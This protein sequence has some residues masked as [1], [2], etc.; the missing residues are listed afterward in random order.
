MRFFS[1]AA[2]LGAALS[3]FSEAGPVVSPAVSHNTGRMGNSL[4]A[5]HSN[6]PCVFDLAKAYLDEILYQGVCAP[7]LPGI[8]PAVYLGLTLPH[9]QVSGAVSI[10]LNDMFLIAPTVRVNLGGV[11]VAV[12]LDLKASAAVQQSVE[13]FA[14]PALQVDIPGLVDIE[15]GAA[16]ALD[17]LVGVSAAVDI[18]AG[19]YV[20]LPDAAFIEINLLTKAISKSNLEGLL[21]QALPVALGAGVDLAAEIDLNLGLRLRTQVGVEAG[22]DCVGLEAGA[23][24]ALWVDLFDYT[25]TLAHTDSCALSVA[26][27]L[28]VVAGVAVDVGVEVKDI[29][30]ISLAPSVLVTLA[31]AELAK[32]CHAT[33]PHYTATSTALALPGATGV[34]R[35]GDGAVPTGSVPAGVFPPSG[36]LRSGVIPSGGAVFPTGAPSGLPTGG[37]STDTGV[38]VDPTAVVLG[39]PTITGAPG[40]GSGSGAD[41]LTTS[42]IYSTIVETITSCAHTVTNCPAGPHVTTRTVAVGTTVCPLSN[43]APTGGPGSIGTISAIPYGNSSVTS[44]PG[45]ITSTVTST[46]VYTITSCAASVPN[47]PA[48]L[49]QKIITSTVLIGTTV[50]PATMVTATATSANTTPAVVVPTPTGTPVTVTPCPTPVTSTYTA[51]SNIPTPAP[52]VII[53][54][55]ATANPETSGAATVPPSATYVTVPTNPARIVS[56][57]APLGTGTGVV[58]PVIATSVPPTYVVPSPTIVPTAVPT[59]GA[60]RVVAGLAAMGLPVLAMML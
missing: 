53:T 21:A 29:L 20:T 51:P 36:A 30:D 42:T 15:L 4:N 9:A 2:L 6:Q 19:V 38:S 56:G 26:D 8:Q 35:V 48:S 27:A 54:E 12:E 43:A 57:T 46:A 52:T 7:A 60:G 49:T 50:C 47:C 32:I 55:T 23:Q 10:E 40:S 18:Q 45:L 58:P 33:V 22:L 37:A 24:V 41:P 44:A 16:F 11:K 34:T 17:L 31:T 28:K 14:S 3:G 59:A 39:E 25:S 13:L 5:R 1:S